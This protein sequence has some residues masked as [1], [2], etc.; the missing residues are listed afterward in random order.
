MAVTRKS[1]I[2][3]VTA[4]NDTTSIAGSGL[5]IKAIKLVGGSDA[6]TVRIKETDTNGMV[7]FGLNAAAN[8]SDDLYLDGMRID[9]ATLHF[10]LTGTGPEV[11][12]Y[13]E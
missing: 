3:R 1:N 10:D 11:F 13:L 9:V 12:I 4:D 6:S 8:S 2:I 7:L 5:R